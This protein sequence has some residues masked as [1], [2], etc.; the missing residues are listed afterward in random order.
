MFGNLAP[1]FPETKIL[2][3]ILAFSSGTTT[4]IVGEGT[5]VEAAIL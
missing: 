2:I 4:A 1:V 3:L 5:P